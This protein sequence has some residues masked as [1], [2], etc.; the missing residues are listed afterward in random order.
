[1][2]TLNVFIQKGKCDPIETDTITHG[3]NEKKVSEQL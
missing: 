1:M 3:N 2:K